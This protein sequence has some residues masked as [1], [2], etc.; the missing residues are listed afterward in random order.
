MLRPTEP[1]RVVP[2]T[3]G[4]RLRGPASPKAGPFPFSRHVSGVGYRAR[5]AAA[6]FFDLDRTLLAGASGEVFSAAMRE[7]GLVSRSIPGEQLLY[8]V[9]NTIGET[10]PSMALARQAVTLAKGRDRKSTRLN[11]SHT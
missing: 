5:V 6:A 11:S 3:T 8:K 9:F 2:P 1:K 10:L 7:A 4:S